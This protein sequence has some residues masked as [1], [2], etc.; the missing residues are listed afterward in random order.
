MGTGARPLPSSRSTRTYLDV[1]DVTEMEAADARYDERTSTMLGET[2]ALLLD[3]S[4][5]D[6]RRLREEASQ[7]P[8]TELKLI[9]ECKAIG[10]V[11]ADIYFRELQR[12]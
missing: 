10:D 7:Q 3:R 6:L 9:K 4:R 12:E 1:R 11:G 8:A 2:S 5:G